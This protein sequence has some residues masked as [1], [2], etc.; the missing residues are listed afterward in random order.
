MLLVFLPLAAC[1]PP[2]PVRTIAPVDRPLVIPQSPPPESIQPGFNRAE[3]EANLL[4]SARARYGELLVRR[5]IAAPA[6]LF[7]KH[8]PGMLPPPP[9]GAGPDWRD[10]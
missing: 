8:Y 2:Q 10:E 9:P 7:T 3:V 6:F 4:A 1:T 5:A